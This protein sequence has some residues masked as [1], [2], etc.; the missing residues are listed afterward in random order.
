MIPIFFS[1]DPIF[2]FI[3]PIVIKIRPIQRRNGDL[4][5][6]QHKPIVFKAHISSKLLVRLWHTTAVNEL[7]HTHV[8]DPFDF[9]V[10]TTAAA[11]AAA[12]NNN[13]DD[14]PFGGGRRLCWGW[15]C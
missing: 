4:P 13:N 11:A 3:F 6:P 10:L 14:D 12:A 5:E 9:L 7:P 8:D 2:I 1:F 15:C